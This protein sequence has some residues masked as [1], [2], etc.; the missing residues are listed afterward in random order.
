MEPDLYALMLHQNYTRH[1][2]SI[3]ECATAMEYLCIADQF[4]SHLSFGHAGYTQ[5]IQMQPYMTSLAVRGMLFA[6]TSAG[7]ASASSSFGGP[8]KH[9]WPELFAVNRTA[10]ANDEMFTEVASDLAGRE[11][12]GLAVGSVTGPGGSIVNCV[13]FKVPSVFCFPTTGN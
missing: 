12:Y 4:Q 8:K 7:P 6:P 9:W 1:M 5:T 11:A 10:R 2:R 3:E 13:S